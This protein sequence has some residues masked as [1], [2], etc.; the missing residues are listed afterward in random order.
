MQ[1][2]VN[3]DLS[4]LVLAGDTD[5]L[6]HAE[7]PYRQ[8]LELLPVAVYTCSA[9]SGVITFYNSQATTL[10][11]RTPR[12][13][14]TNERFCGSLRLF[15]PDGRPLP[16]DQT[17]MAVALA[18]GRAFR[19]EE[20]VIE[21][22]GGRRIVARVSIDPICDG[23]GH[24]VG[25]IN[26]VQDVTERR[27]AEHA[28]AQLAAIVAS[29]DDAIV[30][31]NLDGT[32]T[33]W[34]A[35][36]ERIFG[37][38]ADEAVGRSITLIIPP[39]RLDEEVGIL[40]RLRR[41]ERVDHYETVRRRRDGSLL[42]LSITVSPVRDGSGRI[43][44]ASKIARDITA[45]KLAEKA[46]AEEGL[47]RETL[48]RLAAALAGELE[49]DKL[50]QAI[51]DA[52]TA[53]TGA[54]SGAFFYNATDAGGDAFQLYTLSGADRES[55]AQFPKP[56]TTALFA[57]TFRGDGPIR[58]DD[59]TADPRYGKDTL[60]TPACLKGTRR[61]AATWPCP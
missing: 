52:G 40:E 49:Q 20:V 50:V 35:G 12:L 6:G 56:R 23:A 46:R 5:A 7:Q 8:L 38:S 57:P 59:V 39:D 61:C 4:E 34:N 54:E 27:Q 31:K 15:W 37:Y 55:F 53:L 19:N 22:P 30:A 14:D 26:V 2:A 41:G 24:V 29:S 43:V 58:L 21:Q 60:R 25:A 44:G 48:A 32:I 47:V 17:P 18:E 42:D 10:W 51:T 3:R 9:P 45:N 16:H 33:S 13:G 1:H 11:G 28:Q 36:A